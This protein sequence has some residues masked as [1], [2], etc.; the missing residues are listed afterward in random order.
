MR[1]IL[2]AGLL[3]ILF[4]NACKND[5]HK[6]QAIGFLTAFYAGNYTAAK[7]FA[8][9][10][11]DTLLDALA[12]LAQQMGDT[13]LRTLDE[14]TLAASMQ[15]PQENNDT[16]VIRYQHPFDK[17]RTEELTLY[18]LK[19]QWLVE[20]SL[21]RIDPSRFEELKQASL[22]EDS[23]RTI[24]VSDDAEHNAAVADSVQ[25]IEIK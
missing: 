18:K 14:K 22:P 8:S 23:M 19:N 6:K 11:T 12:S 16:C 3:A 2:G 5:A 25:L 17:A 24:S 9:P 20:M 7:E 10:R 21:D 13:A 4:F 1:K 15:E